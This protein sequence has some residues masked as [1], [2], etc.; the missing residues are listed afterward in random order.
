MGTPAGTA[1]RV[2]KV[3]VGLLNGVR[4]KGYTYDFSPLKEVFN[5]FPQED[6]L[7]EKAIKVEMKDLK[8]VFF[9]AD[10]SGNPEYHERLLT[11]EPM[12]GREIEVTFQD[13]EKIVGRTE[14][15]NPQKSGF[16]MFPADPKTN[17]IRIF[18]VIRNTRQIRI[19]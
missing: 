10:F 19:L 3:V 9:V 11:D 13:G 7:R 1:N 17:N 2:T 5:L 14:G 16:F 15:Y 6:P 12:H 18:V 4:L 8:A